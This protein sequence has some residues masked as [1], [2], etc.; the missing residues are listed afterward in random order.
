MEEKT[1]KTTIIYGAVLSALL[2]KKRVV[3]LHWWPLGIASQ[4]SVAPIGG[5][6]PYIRLLRRFGTGPFHLA[7]DEG[8][9]SVAEAAFCLFVSA[10]WRLLL[11]QKSLVIS[12]R[13]EFRVGS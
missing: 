2:A 10:I 9:F 6:R 5:L 3:E 13:T 4:T 7:T 12:N 1:G 8:W 11:R